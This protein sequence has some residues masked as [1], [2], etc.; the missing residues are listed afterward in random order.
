MDRVAFAALFLLCL[1]LTSC[2]TTADVAQVSSETN[3]NGNIEESEQLDANTSGIVTDSSDLD[4]PLGMEIN[5]SSFTA[6]VYISSLITNDDVYNFPDTNHITFEPGAR[7]NW[8]SHGG[9]VILVTGG[10]GYYQE[11][12]QPAQIIRKGDV[13]ECAEG[14]R[15]WHGAAP[16]SWFSQI[17]IW[18][19]DYVSAENAEAEEPVTEE[20]YENLEAV[21]YTGRTVT[22]DNTFMFQQ[23]QTSTTLS[24]FS[25]SVYVSS[26]IG[27]NNVAGTPELHYVV[28]EQ[29]VINNWHIHE[30]GQILIVTDGIGYHQI[31]GEPVQVL[32][33]GDVVFCPPGVMHWHGGSADTEFAHISINT[34]PELTG[35]QW[36]DR[37]S[38]EEYLALTELTDND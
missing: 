22:E 33:P 30:G 12:G 27:R 3:G 9:M 21:E 8:H 11:E 19:S 7:S 16:D 4:F 20:E 32:Y 1:M 5:S 17:V 36:F 28:F 31:E 13:I 18:D 26:L 35:L 25:G 29:G 37:I 10:V 24:T 34:N 6:T 14:V 23:A 38:N 15:H 2:G